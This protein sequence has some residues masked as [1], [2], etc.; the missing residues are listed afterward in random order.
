MVINTVANL[1]HKIMITIQEYEQA[2]KVIKQYESEQLDLLRVSNSALE[3]KKPKCD[4]YKDGGGCRY[5]GVC[6]IYDR[7]KIKCSC[8]L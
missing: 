3:E 8:G 2:Q 4:H 6:Q 7:S 5:S 1:K